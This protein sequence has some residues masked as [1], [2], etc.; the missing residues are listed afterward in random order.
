MTLEVR[1][2]DPRFEADDFI[3]YA[4]TM[5]IGQKF[6][7]FFTLNLTVKRKDN[8]SRMLIYKRTYFLHNLS[9]YLFLVPP[10]F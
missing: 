2:D 10:Q 8:H 3:A 9:N 4:Q 5:F 1:G 7:C 6:V